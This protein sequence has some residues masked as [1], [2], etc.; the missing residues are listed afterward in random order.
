M[1]GHA[2]VL[3]GDVLTEKK[4]YTPIWKQE[5]KG[6]DGRKRFHG[7]F[8][9]GFSAG[10]YNTVGSKEGIFLWS[11]CVNC[12]MGTYRLCFIQEC[13][14]CTAHNENATRRVYG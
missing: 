9:G 6:S 11:C 12:R 4:K 14:I 5:A 10:Y 8:T 7:A 13:K 1:D 3:Y 2:L